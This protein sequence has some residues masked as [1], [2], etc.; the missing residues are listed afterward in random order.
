M[1]KLLVVTAHPDDESFG[2]GGTLAYYA[3]RG[4]EVRVICATRG[5]AGDDAVVKSEIRNP[6][7]Q[8]RELNTVREHELLSASNMLGVAKVEFL[9]FIDGTLNNEQYHNVAEKITSVI[10]EF[11]PQVILTFEPRGVSGHLDHVAISFIT[12]FAYQKSQIPQKLYYYCLPREFTDRMGNYLNEY[13]VYFP[14]GYDQSVITT[15][16]DISGVWDKRIAAIKEHH[17][18]QKDIDNVLKFLEL[19]NK[20]VDHFILFDSRVGATTPET[21]FFAGL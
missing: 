12:T 1:K 21:D 19:R 9:D 8:K 15:R 6:K 13:F 16:I 17:S 14:K 18:Q 20:Q 7:S 3:S 11:E 10:E 4:V 2:P 5:E